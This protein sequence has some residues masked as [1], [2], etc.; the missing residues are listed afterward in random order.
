MAFD[1]IKE[2]GIQPAETYKY[3][4]RQEECKFDKTKVV[5]SISD[6]VLYHNSSENEQELQRLV[7]ERG[8][9][10]VG[11][12]AKF[13]VSV[14]YRSG[15]YQCSNDSKRLN[16]AVLVVGYDN[17]NGQDYW[18]IKNSWGEGWG[19]KGYFK[20]ARNIGTCGIGKYYT[21]PTL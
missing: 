19:E 13:S 4:G 20:L 14:F 12:C 6:Y 5:T 2:H 21:V 9:V 16:H 1:Y 17:E 18:L 10:A 3:V 11:L 15:I 8:P 7:A